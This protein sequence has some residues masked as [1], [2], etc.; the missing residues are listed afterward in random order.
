M[1]MNQKRRACVLLL[2]SSALGLG[3]F[4]AAQNYPNKP[5]R[6]IVPFAAG[7]GTDAMARAL[8]DK[9]GPRLGQSVIVE[10]KSG[11]GGIVGTEAV[12]K[13][14]PDGYTLMV[15][16]TTNL[17]INQ[18]LYSSLPY[19]PQKDLQLVSQIGTAAIILL[20]HPSVPA[21]NAQELVNYIKKNKGK[22]AYGS[23]GIGSQA[24]LAGAHMSQT[25]NAEMS[26]VPYRGEAPML[27]DLIGGR[28]QI[29]FGSPL[30]AKGF[31]ETGKL[32]A[33]GI[34]GEQ[35]LSV[36]PDIPTLSEQ[37]LKDDIYRITG[38]YAVAAPAGTPK[39]IVKRI[40]DEVK[41]AMQLPDIRTRFAAVGGVPTGT[42]PE[43]LEAIYA[44]DYPVWE[45][46]VKASGA[47]AD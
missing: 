37:G 40:S 35:R 1:A 11:A 19:N 16:L 41:A 17:L 4:A 28:I 32:K 3:N 20:A 14:P 12:A 46:A 8:A 47:R 7:G 38:W 33:I 29:G 36:V 5:I 30:T 15:G 18:F 45:Q 24:H 9:L 22:V 2:A 42:S 13:A 10:N 34:T 6:I 21:N 23:Y 44:R 27:Q 26:H 39:P 31:L 25:L 43:E